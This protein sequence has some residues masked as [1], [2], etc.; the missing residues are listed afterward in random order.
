[1]R[2]LIVEQ[3][4]ILSGPMGIF[5]ALD[6]AVEPDK[7]EVEHKAHRLRQIAEI[8]QL[9]EKHRVSTGSY[10]TFPWDVQGS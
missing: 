9:T 8:A 6:E 7:H 1:M 2:I 4:L 5:A 3:R 10:R